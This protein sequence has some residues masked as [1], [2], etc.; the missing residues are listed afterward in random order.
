MGFARPE[1][2]AGAAVGRFATAGV[3]RELYDQ[4]QKDWVGKV[5][6]RS[7]GR[8]RTTPFREAVS[9]VRQAQPRTSIKGYFVVHL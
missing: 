5:C 9:R 2:V 8:T 3:G 4:T 6:G 7:G 1:V